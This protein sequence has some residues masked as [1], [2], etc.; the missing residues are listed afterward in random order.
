MTRTCRRLARGAAVTAHLTVAMALVGLWLPPLRCILSRRRA[1]LH[2]H[3]LTRWWMRSLLGILAV[4]LEIAGAAAPAPA[5]VVSNHVSWLDIPCLLAALDA[6]FVAKTEVAHWPLI[7]RL[8][9]GVGTLFLVR[10]SGAAHVADTMTF[11]L[12]AG[13]RMAIFPEGTST[14]GRSVRPFHARLYQAAIRAT[15]PVQAVAIRYPLAPGE[16]NP[17]VP[18]VGNDA[19][20]GHLWRLLGEREIVAQLHYCP[21]LTGG[22]VTRRVLAETTHH[23]IAAVLG[24]E[25]PPLD[26]KHTGTTGPESPAALHSP[27]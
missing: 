26:R 17:L 20:L 15:T 16:I 4:R 23:Q 1:S 8:A 10:G 24:Q 25:S 13:E 6:R 12:L 2:R 18:F 19:F 27:C 9:A 11:A 5:L 14:D 22:N 21:P 7:G 3:R